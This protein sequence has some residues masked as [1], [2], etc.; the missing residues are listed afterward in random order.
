MS[1]LLAVCGSKAIHV[2]TDACGTEPHDGVV[3]A[4]HSKQIIL[5]N[6]VLVGC[7]S[8]YDSFVRF[9]EFASMR[10]DFDAVRQAS[11]MLWESARAVLGPWR[12]K[13]CGVLIG[14]WSKSAGRLRMDM[15]VTEGDRRLLW[16][17]VSAIGSGP[18]AP[19]PDFL[20]EFNERF[21]ADPGAFSPRRDGLLIVERLRRESLRSFDGAMRSV[22]GGYCQLSTLTPTTFKSRVLR[23]WPDE[24]GRHIR[25]DDDAG[26]VSSS[27]VPWSEQYRQH[28]DAMRKQLTRVAPGATWVRPRQA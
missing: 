16:P 7:H 1:A 28:K 9:A 23:F 4:I 21:S 19:M 24:V 26:S 5:P 18:A 14:G 17:D 10:A 22:V 3:G 27:G 11:S 20:E 2:L 12:D 6:S 25:L 8:L 13:R 15:M